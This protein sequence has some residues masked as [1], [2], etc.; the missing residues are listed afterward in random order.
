M[1]RKAS[2]PVIRNCTKCG[3]DMRMGDR[4]SLVFQWENGM[5]KKPWNVSGKLCRDCA[6]EWCDEMGI[7]LPPFYEKEKK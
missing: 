5:R 1:Q 3:A 4:V 6:A 7:P 2:F